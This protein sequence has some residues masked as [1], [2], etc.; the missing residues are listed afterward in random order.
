MIRSDYFYEYLTIGNGYINIPVILFS[1]MHHGNDEGFDKFL[2]EVIV[3]GIA[4]QQIANIKKYGDEWQWTPNEGMDDYLN[5]W[6][7][8]I[9]TFAS[10]KVFNDTMDRFINWISDYGYDDWITKSKEAYVGITFKALNEMLYSSY[11]SI[12]EKKRMEHCW[13]IYHSLKSMLGKN[14]PTKGHYSWDNVLNRALGSTS[15]R[16]NICTEE[17]KDWTLQYRSGKGYQSR[18]K[19]DVIKRLQENWGINYQPKDPNT[20]KNYKI[21]KFSIRQS[22]FRKNVNHK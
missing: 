7:K 11:H 21:P 10:K 14:N 6:G 1:V 13:I 20:G 8:Y 2:Y 18:K 17:T 3:W 12:R 19:M 9:N 5:N 15:L 16:N 22:G 4:T